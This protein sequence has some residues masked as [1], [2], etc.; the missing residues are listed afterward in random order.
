MVKP[1]ARQLGVLS[2]VLPR[3]LSETRGD[4]QLTVYLLLS[5]VGIMLVFLIIPLLSSASNVAAS[6]FH[7]QVKVLQ[8]GAS[9]NGGGSGGGGTSS[10]Y[11][12]TTS[13]WDTTTTASNSN[14]SNSSSS[15]SGYVDT[16]SWDPTNVTSRSTTPIVH[17]ENL[18]G[19]EG[20]VIQAQASVPHFTPGMRGL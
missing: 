17:Q 2:R 6:V 20:T 16:G 18:G 4:S 8:Q 3:L 10:G 1:H 13:T 7:L 15:S 14:G 9:S 5:A 19:S 12:D 11:V